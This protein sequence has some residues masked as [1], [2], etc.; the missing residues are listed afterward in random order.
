[1]GVFL[2]SMLQTPYVMDTI[3]DIS[4]RDLPAFCRHVLPRIEPHIKLTVRG[5]NLDEYRRDELK[6]AF[7]LD[8]PYP[9]EVTLRVEHRYGGLTVNPLDDNTNTVSYTH[10][11]VYKRQVHSK[12][13]VFRPCH[14][15]PFT[16]LHMHAVQRVSA[17]YMALMQRSGRILSY[18]LVEEKVLVIGGEVL[19][20][21]VKLGVFFW[22]LRILADFIS[23]DRIRI[24]YKF[25][26][27]MKPPN[28]LSD[29][30]FS[31][32]A[33]HVRRRNV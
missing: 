1:M 11:D 25:T 16:A 20:G 6:T 4:S 10:L 5:I 33:L 2:A 30:M 24:G 26:A 22:P 14:H 13:V 7:Y 21:E 8:C 3:A 29:L 18:L 15:F 31:I 27:H 12:T 17:V 19:G 9:D 28:N 32:I 23:A